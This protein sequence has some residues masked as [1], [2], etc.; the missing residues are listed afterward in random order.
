MHC[1]RLLVIALANLP[2]NLR[3]YT[4]RKLLPLQLESYYTFTITLPLSYFYYYT[5]ILL[6]PT[7]WLKTT[8]LTRTLAASL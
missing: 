5:S 7:P 1:L 2:E 8:H 6:L 4:E 3:S